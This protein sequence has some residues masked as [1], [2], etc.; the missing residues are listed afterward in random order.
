MKIPTYDRQA[1][2]PTTTGGGAISGQINPNVLGGL[3]EPAITAGRQIQ[4]LG[5]DWM[6]AE[7]AADNAAALA[8]EEGTFTA[9]LMSTNE[10]IATQ[11]VSEWWIEAPGEDSR[12]PSSEEKK[13]AIQRRLQDKRKRMISKIRNGVVRQEFAAWSAGKIAQATPG[14]NS[15][16][17]SRFSDYHKAMYHVER[18]RRL[19]A[20]H[21]ST[22]PNTDERD[23]A[24]REHRVSLR[25]K[26]ILGG[27]TEEE[28]TRH[29]RED[30]VTIATADVSGRISAAKTFV[31]AQALADA[32]TAGDVGK[33]LNVDKRLSLA[34]TVQKKADSLLRKEVANRDKETRE[35]EAEVKADQVSLSAKYAA[36]IE[37]ALEAM[38]RGEFGSEA[39]ENLPTHA[40]LNEDLEAGRLTEA[41]HKRLVE[42]LEGRDA[43]RNPD[44]YQEITGMIYDAVNEEDL[45]FLQSKIKNAHASGQLG[46]KGFQSVVQVWRG[47]REKTPAFKEAKSYRAQLGQIISKTSGPGNIP[48]VLGAY[49]D[50]A[51]HS[52]VGAVNLFNSKIADGMRPAEAFYTTL[53]AFIDNDDIGA[54][55]MAVIR[56][57]PSDIASIFPSTR[58]TGIDAG[59][60]YVKSLTKDEIDAAWEVWRGMLV[61]DLDL[62]GDVDQTRKLS[63]RGVTP[64]QLRKKQFADSPKDR[65]TRDQRITVRKLHTIEEQLRFLE[66][67]VTFKE[68]IKDA[69][70]GEGAGDGGEPLEVV[71]DPENRMSEDGFFDDPWDYL[72]GSDD[73]EEGETPAQLLEELEKRGGLNE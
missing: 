68:A 19:T 70:G 30:E 6:V 27:W 37:T 5:L 2:F 39:A 69:G 10:E 20:I 41:S 11:S 25:K 72:F 40:D 61:G 67:T 26:A 43:I 49:V 1:A 45:R 50:E 58:T 12:L 44:Y 23:V 48:P 29:W 16:I 38:N 36:R 65:I 32:L 64:E 31:D 15:A 54:Q 57:L 59:Q 63:L 73:E 24:M 33:E 35:A 21:Q 60:T 47:A 34:L 53:N 46:L 28:T 51:V 17:R 13:A 62:K 7:L 14:L 71:I 55:A 18:N 42:K 3:A 52:R 22:L 9:F 56:G 4:K 8:S 66:N